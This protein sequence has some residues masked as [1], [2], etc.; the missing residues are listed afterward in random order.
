MSR[1]IEVVGQGNQRKVVFKET[2]T[3]D[4]GD[5]ENVIKLEKDLKGELMRIRSEVKELK[6]R[7]ESIHE[8]LKLIKN[9][10]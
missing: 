4:L 5:A 6:K 7:A 1:K 3:V 2:K 9:P 10:R 8:I